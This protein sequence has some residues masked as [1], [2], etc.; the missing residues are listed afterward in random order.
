[1]QMIEYQTT[2]TDSGYIPFPPEIRKQLVLKP[3][4]K[5]RV[6]IEKE[7][8]PV[9]VHVV[10]PDKNEKKSSG[11]CGIWE[12]ERD[13]DEIVRELRALRSL[14]RECDL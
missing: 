13:A 10:I 1:M 12:D 9:T 14:G 4:Q 6:I 5:I 7:V 8:S 2:L 3:D 11:L